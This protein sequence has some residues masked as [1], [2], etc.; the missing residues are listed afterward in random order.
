MTAMRKAIRTNDIAFTL[1]YTIMRK[2]V[3]A[4][5]G[6]INMTTRKAEPLKVPHMLFGYGELLNKD[7]DELYKLREKYSGNDANM[8]RILDIIHRKEMHQQN[9]QMERMTK[10]IL[11]YTCIMTV[12]T[13]VMLVLAALP[14]IHSIFD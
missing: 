8:V 1:S 13:I 2:P 10:S 4:Y 14:S 11:C 6:R 7:L 9:K 3:I 12:S 5:Y